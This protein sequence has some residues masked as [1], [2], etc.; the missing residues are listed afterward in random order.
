[1]TE[2]VVLPRDDERRAERHVMVDIETIA[3]D[4]GGVFFAVALVPFDPYAGT[5]G[6]SFF[7]LIDPI[8]AMRYGLKPDASTIK[9]WSDQAPEARAY[10]E[11]AYTDGLPLG[12]A[13]QRMSD[14]LHAEVGEKE[15][16][17]I[18][19]KGGDFDKPFLDL[20]Y[21]ACGLEK[22]WGMRACRCYRS[23][24][25]F[26]SVPPPKR[27]L[28]GVSHHALDDTIHQVQ[29]AIPV[30]RDLYKLPVLTTPI[31]DPPASEWVDDPIRASQALAHASPIDSRPRRSRAP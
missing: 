24:E 27:T 9:W 16:L 18:W 26:A 14:Y 7:V 8:D 28:T 6:K 30:L 23:L 4:A 31:L 17:R 12:V 10:L 25:A 5:M 2:P 11:A 21:E 20:A 13:M 15:S 22:P 1:M 3:K 19:G 29:Y